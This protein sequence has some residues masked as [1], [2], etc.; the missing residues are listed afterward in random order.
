MLTRPDVGLQPRT[1]AQLLP[2]CGDD[3]HVDDRRRRPLTRPHEGVTAL[4]RRALDAGEIQRHACPRRGAFDVAMRRLDPPYPDGGAGR[5]DLERVADGDGPS[6]QRPGQKRRTVG[7][8]EGADVPDVVQVLRAV[9]ADLVEER[10]RR[11]Q[12]LQAEHEVED[13]ERDDDAAKRALGHCS[14]DP[15]CVRWRRNRG[16]RI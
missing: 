9:A 15:C 4:E 3:G 7:G 2:G 8:G 11:Q 6:H 10:P 5:A 12:R 1:A 13:T 16:A 14:A